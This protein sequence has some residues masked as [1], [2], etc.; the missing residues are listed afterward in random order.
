MQGALVYMSFKVPKRPCGTPHQFTRI[1][2]VRRNAAIWRM[3]W[4]VI[5]RLSAM[6][7]HDRVDWN[8]ISWLCDLMNAAHHATHPH[9]LPQ[10]THPTHTLTF[11]F[12]PPRTSCL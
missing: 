6:G 8:G 2:A 1:I 12:R 11:A 5:C 10:P 3:I 7:S 4:R 9:T